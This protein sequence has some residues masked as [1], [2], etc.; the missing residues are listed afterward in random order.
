[1]LNCNDKNRK[2]KKHNYA[3]Y[4]LFQGL[5]LLLASGLQFTSSTCTWILFWSLT[6]EFCKLSSFNSA[7]T[8]TL[9]VLSS[10]P[11][12]FCYFS[13]FKSNCSSWIETSLCCF[14]SFCKA[15]SWSS[16]S[17]SLTCSYTSSF[18][19]AMPVVY[20]ISSSMQTTIPLFMHLSWWWMKSW[21]C[22]II[23]WTDVWKLTIFSS[24][25]TTISNHVF[26]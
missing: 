10:T 17:V 26:Q 11:T 6:F 18:S 8:G 4:F 3:F 20:D 14:S 19:L 1:M 2:K 24:V 15:C 7:V 13:S 16:S 9:A 23:F 12:E 5:L 25:A 21:I 22:A